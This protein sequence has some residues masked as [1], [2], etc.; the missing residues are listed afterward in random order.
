MKELGR[1]QFLTAL[2][3]FTIAR[4]HARKARVFEMELADFLGYEE[5]YMGILSDALYDDGDRSFESALKAEKFTV[6]KE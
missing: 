3:L 2:A 4:S 1:S 5:Q 6:A